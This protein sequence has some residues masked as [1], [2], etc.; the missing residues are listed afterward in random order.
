MLEEVSKK[1]FVDNYELR[2]KKRTGTPFW[3][4]SS[5]RPIV[6]AGKP[7]VIGASIDI[8]AFKQ[9]Q[10]RLNESE[11]RFRTIAEAAPVLICITGTEDSKV[12]F[13]NELNNKAFGMRGK[14]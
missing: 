1:G 4:L 13:T 2:A 7:A 12:L 5:V 3:I 11:A 10:L 9:T 14:M 6:Y 8:T